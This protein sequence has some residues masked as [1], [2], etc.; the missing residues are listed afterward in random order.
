MA[1][2]AESS[3][4]VSS[5]QPKARRIEVVVRAKPKTEDSAQPTKEEYFQ[6]HVRL[7]YVHLEKL[8]CLLRGWCKQ[9]SFS[10]FRK[11]SLVFSSVVLALT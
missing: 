7:V 11:P 8:C 6:I 1:D 3:A 9:H 5:S 2:D 4:T 10:R